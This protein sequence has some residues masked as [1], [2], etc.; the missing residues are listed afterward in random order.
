MSLFL[1][2]LAVILIFFGLVLGSVFLAYRKWTHY[3]ENRKAKKSFYS[4]Q[5]AESLES[6]NKLPDPKQ[7]RTQKQ[8]H[9]NYM[10]AMSF[11]SMEKTVTA[12]EYWKKI[13][14]NTK[15]QKFK[16]EASYYLGVNYWK[17]KKYTEALEQFMRIIERYKESPLAGDSLYY[18]A[19]YHFQND[20]LLKA[21]DIYENIVLNFP[22]SKNIEKAFDKLG[23]LNIKLLFSKVE[24]PIS[25]IY[26]VKPGDS[27]ATI[28]K[29]HN[30][31]VGLLLKSNNMRTSRINPN[32][33][34][35]LITARFSLLID[36]SQN[37]LFLKTDEKFFKRY[38]VG[39]GKQ[40][41][42]PVGTFKIT[43]KLKNPTWYRPDGGVVP[44]GTKENFLGT[45]WMSIDYP[46]YGIH[47]T[48]K[49]DT[50]GHQSSMGCIRLM[51]VLL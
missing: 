37:V 48:W 38:H 21:R 22:E 14:A 27:L 11:Q 47:G 51:I 28:A 35:K 41:S 12:N 26:I 42:T 44:F 1:K 50:V 39:T 24:T 36:K 7:I 29:K 6:L 25:D 49:P 33:R 9:L 18:I 15:Y 30:T 13:L 17:E 31:T 8:L 3:T 32:D 10:R 45:R 5:Y 19:T 4:A 46:G 23:N 16:D 2:R 43:E 40:N 34:L 20:E